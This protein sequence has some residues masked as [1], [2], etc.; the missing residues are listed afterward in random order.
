MPTGSRIPL[1][2]HRALGWP[3]VSS[4]GEAKERW[5]QLARGLHQDRV[6]DGADGEVVF[7]RFGMR[8]T[9]SQ[10]RDCFM[11]AREANTWV[12][13]MVEAGTEVDFG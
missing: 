2:L 1:R 5:K 11:A 12:R 3:L 7:E 8:T 10:A 6:G 4:C 9:R 13:D